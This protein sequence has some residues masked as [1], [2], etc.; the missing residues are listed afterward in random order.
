MPEP[1]VVYGVRRKPLKAVGSLLDALDDPEAKSGTTT[2]SFGDDRQTEACTQG[3]LVR[4]HGAPAQ[5]WEP[6]P[7]AFFK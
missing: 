6:R 5:P 7:A 3:R 1:T 4:H 2:R